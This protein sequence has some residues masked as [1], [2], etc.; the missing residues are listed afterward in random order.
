MKNLFPAALVGAV[1]SVP[2]FAQQVP[3]SPVTQPVAEAMPFDI[4]YGTPLNLAQA[5]KAIAA[6]EAEATKHGWKLVCAVAE[7]TGD[8]IS[9][10]KMDGAQYGSIQVAQDKART[11]ARFRRPTKAFF[12]Q[13]KAG[14][15]YVL[16]LPGTISAE[17][18]FPIVHDGK[19]VGAI[20]CSGAI[21]N[22][23]ATAAY[24]GAEVL[25]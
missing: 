8:L 13:T 4:P 14:N 11:A 6:A 16:S 5:R 22:Q 17:G 18:G 1:L 2:V 19:L 24:A 15:L 3:E 9:L 23:D 10:D 12:D 20:G 21:G 25:K 7:P